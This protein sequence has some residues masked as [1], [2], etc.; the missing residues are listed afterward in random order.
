MDKLALIINVPSE[1]FEAKATL[2]CGQMFRYEKLAENRYV[3]FSGDKKCLLCTEG[4][5]TS[6]FARSSDEQ[7]FFNFFDLATDYGA[8]AK[9]LGAYDE[10]DEV[11]KIGK[12]I[13][14]LRQNLVETIISFIISAN[15]NI[16]RIKKIIS[17]LCQ[18][19]GKQMDG[20]YAFPT[21]EE[22]YL[23]DFAD[24]QNIGAGFRD[25]YLFETVR[26]LKETDVIERIRSGK[27]VTKTL[28]SLKGVGPKVA[29]CISLFGLHDMAGFPVDTW[30]FKKCKSDI[31]DTPSKVHDY[32]TARYGK[33]AGLA[34]QYIFYGAKEQMQNG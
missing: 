12:G 8:I 21:L 30:I 7:Y 3:A 1:Y 22:M 5:T 25:R 23:M 16:P 6:V 4:E 19:A 13:R 18:M 10:L 11:I 27:N 28:L 33:Y 9:E 15:N 20:Y 31:L 14:I 24:W 29:D 32:Y 17:R 26:I 2:E 34:Q